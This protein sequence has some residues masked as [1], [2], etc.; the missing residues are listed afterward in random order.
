MRENP[1]VPNHPPV[2]A[3][4][5]VAEI[6][7]LDLAGVGAVLQSFEVKEFFTA[8]VIDDQAALGIEETP[9]GAAAQLKAW[10]PWFNSEGP[11]MARDLWRAGQRV[12]ARIAT[13]N[14]EELKSKRKARKW[15]MQYQR[16]P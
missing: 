4:V 1:L 3:E 11:K 12:L 15:R 5:T 16:N 2:G 9:E 7:E 8:L 6:V 14:A 10:D 13:A